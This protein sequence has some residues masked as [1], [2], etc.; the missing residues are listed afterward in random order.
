MRY[1]F[2]RSE[3]MVDQFPMAIGRRLRAMAL[4]ERKIEEKISL[5]A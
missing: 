1:V 3:I 2:R 5:V 4:K